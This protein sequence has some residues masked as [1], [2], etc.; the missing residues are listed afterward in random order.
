MAVIWI[1]AIFEFFLFI[2]CNYLILHIPTSTTI[3]LIK[4]KI[5]PG[6]V[7]PSNAVKVKLLCHENSCALH[8]LEMTLWLRIS[9]WILYMLCLYVYICMCVY[10]YV[11]IYIYCIYI[12]V[13]MHWFIFIWNEKSI[14]HS[15]FTLDKALYGRFSFSLLPLQFVSLLFRLFVFWSFCM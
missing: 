9:F 15:D 11:F 14:S 6:V 7:N 4:G 3:F 10:T 13:Y 2:F 8:E 12:C 5:S 1:S